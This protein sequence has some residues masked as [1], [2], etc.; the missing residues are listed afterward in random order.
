MDKFLLKDC[1]KGTKR[2]S[3]RHSLSTFNVNWQLYH[4]VFKHS[5]HIRVLLS[6]E[7]WL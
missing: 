1:N 6:V 7:G 4:T 2:K 5:Q 3:F